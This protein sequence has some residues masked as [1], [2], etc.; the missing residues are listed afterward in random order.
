MAVTDTLIERPCCTPQDFLKGPYP[1]IR[2]P[3]SLLLPLCL[4]LTSPAASDSLWNDLEAAVQAEL[5]R[6][7]RSTAVP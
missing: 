1:M 4:L 5:N 3:Q 2:W 6:S 7:G